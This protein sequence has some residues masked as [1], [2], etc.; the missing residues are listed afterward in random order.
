MAQGALASTGSGP[1]P[2][3]RVWDGQGLGVRGQC[4]P[5]LHMEP[6]REQCH[7]GETKTRIHTRTPI[8]TH[9]HPRTRTCTRTRVQGSIGHGGQRWAARA[10]ADR[11]RVNTQGAATRGCH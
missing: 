3:G 5:G 4:P 9:T 6:P 1:R 11:R 2:A 7:E 8:H 10:P